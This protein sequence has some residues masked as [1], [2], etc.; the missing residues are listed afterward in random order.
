M[1]S[2]GRSPQDGPPPPRL[3]ILVLGCRLPVYDRCISAIRSTWGARPPADVDVLYLYGRQIFGGLEGVDLDRVTGRSVPDP[4]ENETVRSG[5]VIVCGT[6]DVY[7]DQ[8]D[9]ILRKRLLAFAELTDHGEY[10][11]VYNVCASSYVDVHELRRYVRGLPATGIYHGPLGV[12]G[13][14]GYPFVSGASMLMSMDV[15][16]DLASSADE[17]I[18]ANAGRHADD[19]AMGRWIAERHCEESVQD[20][21]DRIAAGERPTRGERFVLPNGRGM[22]NWVHPSRED[23]L[24]QPGVFHYHFHS[25]RIG[26]LESFHRRFFE[27]VPGHGAV[28]T[29]AEQARAAGTTSTEGTPLVG[30]EMSEGQVGG[31]GGGIGDRLPVE[32]DACGQ[33]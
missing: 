25:Q 24:P 21:C 26:E 29:G 31:E 28:R 27:R 17:I 10:D 5:D 2:N 9:C 6:G 12:C 7:A 23:R 16:A 19:V 11:F 33:T 30:A 32:G 15:V 14:S 22:T 13:Y 1:D 18:A 3:A 20:I 4:G 8:V